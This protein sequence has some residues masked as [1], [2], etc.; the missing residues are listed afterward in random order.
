MKNLQIFSKRG[1]ETWPSWDLVYEWEDALKE[2]LHVPIVEEPQFVRNRYLKRLPMMKYLCI[3]S[4]KMSFSFHMSPDLRFHSMNVS[5]VLP[6]IID[7]YL[8]DEQLIS[9]EKA[10][11]HNPVVF[12]SSR[13]VYDHLKEKGLSL[14]IQ[15]LPLTI[16][17][18]Y[19]ISPDTHFEKQYDLVLMGRQNKILQGFLEEYIKRHKD[20]VYVYRK[21]ENGKFLYFTSAGKELGD[22][23][24]REE[25][26]SLMRKA[27][28]SIYGT[29]GIDDGEERCNGYSQVTPRFLEFIAA[30]CHVI[31]RYKENSDTEFFEL[32]KFCKSIN[33][34]SSFEASLDYDRSHEV[35]IPK[36][37]SFLKKHYTSSIVE[38]IT[39][40][41][42]N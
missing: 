40:N 25:Y 17:D 2:A 36:Y 14:N 29:P 9:F 27:K 23:N 33:D 30:G 28:C 37:A 8:K 32:D 22:I 16:S 11:R 4:G 42:F 41:I 5:T 20:F 6:C 34:Y 35:D 13:E 1:F 26:I 19:A 38:I 10:Y 24:T 18:K 39:N 12:I 21:Q 15:H 3:P 31:A 7:F